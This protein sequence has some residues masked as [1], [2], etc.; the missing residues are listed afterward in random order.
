M[1]HPIAQP[2][3]R[4]LYDAHQRQLGLSTRRP[5]ARQLARDAGS[6]VL[7]HRLVEMLERPLYAF[8]GRW[9]AG[10]QPHGA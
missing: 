3:V 5:Q 1:R 4:A 6:V 9:I 2:R 7:G 8:R 10:I